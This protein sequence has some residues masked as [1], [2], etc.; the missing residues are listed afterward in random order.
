MRLQL[1]RPAEFAC[2]DAG[3]P[4]WTYS[5]TKLETAGAQGKTLTKSAPALC[6]EITSVG[7]NAPGFPRKRSSTS[8]MH[9]NLKTPASSRS[10]QSTKPIRRLT[11]PSDRPLEEKRQ[12]RFTE[13]GH[14]SIRRI[15]DDCT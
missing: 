2:G 1:N 10:Y 7:G 6:A 9:G 3:E 5:G 13:L 15:H 12:F 11:P 8:V 14:F 4:W